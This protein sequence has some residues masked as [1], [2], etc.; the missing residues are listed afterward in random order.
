[1]AESKKGPGRPPKKKGSVR[2][3]DLRIPV[4]ATEKAL[5]M[6]AAES[7]GDAGMAAWARAVLL[8]AAKKQLKRK[9]K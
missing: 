9:V 1:M 7:H 4:N 6:E 8:E 2:A 5:V 3:T